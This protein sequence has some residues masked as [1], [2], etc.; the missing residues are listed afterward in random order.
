MTKYDAY[1]ICTSPRSGS[2]LLC[3]LLAA[4]SVAGNPASYF[5]R[6][7]VDEWAAKLGVAPE[8]AATER[9]VLKAGFRA[10]VLK[11]SNGTGI[12]GLRLQAHSFGF[13]R[14]K[15]AVLYPEELS[16]T[17]R[18]RRAFGATLFVH[19]TR[20]D[21]IEQAVSYLK[22]Q[23]TGLWHMAPDGTE[24]ERLAPHKEPSYD[25]NEIQACAE[26]MAVYDDDWNHWFASEGIEPVCITYDDLSA[27]PLEIL[28]Y[29]L[30]CL[31][32]D[33]AAAD[34]IEPSV[35]KLADSTNQDW[36]ARYRSE[37]VSI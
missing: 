1:V 10:A 4:T 25:S 16:D 36:V 30:D 37:Q 34:G 8:E 21:K 20:P 33:R 31:G 2:T 35:K 28:R 19:L 15:L 23:Q 14:E 32:I 27:D 18:F 26:T 13:F 24:L 17:E 29:L 11:G 9:E 12:F 22:A 5:H 7:S 6:P 3:R